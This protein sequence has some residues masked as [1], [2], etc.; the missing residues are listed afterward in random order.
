MA[1]EQSA[2]ITALNTTLDDFLD[3]QQHLVSDISPDVAPLLDSIRTLVSGGKRMRA[4]LAYWGFRAAGG[5]GLSHQAVQAGVA[6]ELFQGAALIHDDIIDRSATRRGRPSV[7]QSFTDLHGRSGW[8]LDPER[9]GQAAGILTGDLCL[10]F[11]EEAFASIGP[12]TASGTKAREIFNR[13]RAEVMAGQYLDILEEVAG[14]LRTVAGAAGRARTV[15]RFKSAKYSTEHPLALGA[16]I[17][18]A[19]DGLLERFSRFSL[20]LGEAFQLRDDV[21]GVF[22]D[23]ATTG[24][25]AGDDLREGK[26]TLLVAFLRELGTEDQ[27]RN[28]EALLGHASMSDDDVQLIR[29]DLQVSGALGAVEAEISSLSTASATALDEL[30]IAEAPRL[31]LHTLA[32]AAVRRKA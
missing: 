21:L 15:L 2:F 28:L 31:A 7:H 16:A 19:P 6:L 30:D 14:P 12:A 3:R 23:P 20:P 27:V 29:G 1:E 4:L 5:A 32:E 25:P 10:S 24:K 17:A 18:G 26:R 9:F 11:S 22:G 8:Q 13:M